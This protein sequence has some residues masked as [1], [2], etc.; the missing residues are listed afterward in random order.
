MNVPSYGCAPPI[1]AARLQMCQWQ[2]PA[3][4]LQ[5]DGE[6]QRGKMLHFTHAQRL[7]GS[8][9]GSKNRIQN[10]CTT[11]TASAAARNSRFHAVRRQSRSGVYRN[12]GGA[13]RL[14]EGAYQRLQQNS[15]LRLL[16]AVAH[17]AEA[18]DFGRPARRGRR[19]FRD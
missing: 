18:Q 2:I 17:Q 6:G 5:R 1:C 15:T 8:A 4:D 14:D 9:P 16:L 12:R 10:R 7:P 13:A 19:R 11:T 3:E